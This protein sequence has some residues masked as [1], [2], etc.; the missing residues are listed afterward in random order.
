MTTLEDLSDLSEVSVQLLDDSTSEGDEREQSSGSDQSDEEK[1]ELDGDGRL[2]LLQKMRTRMRLSNLFD[3]DDLAAVDDEM[4]RVVEQEKNSL[5]TKI[6][7]R[8]RILTK[9]DRHL[10]MS[11]H[12]PHL[13]D[14]FVR[15]QLQMQKLASAAH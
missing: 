8:L 2:S 14:F 3:E 13:N 15:K 1:Y 10:C 11:D 9:Y 7:E 12:H 5:R 6:K 4:A